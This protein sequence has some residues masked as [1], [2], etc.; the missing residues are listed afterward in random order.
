MGLLWCV[1][2]TRQR[3][4]YRYRELVRATEYGW[5]GWVIEIIQPSGMAYVKIID[6][7]SVYAQQTQGLAFT[8]DE[9]YPY[10]HEAEVVV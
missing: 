9:I 2:S 5:L 10:W 1:I 4:L 6:R 8:I 7:A 3:Q